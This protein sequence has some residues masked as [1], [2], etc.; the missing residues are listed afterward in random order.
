M[1]ELTL[2]LFGFVIVIILAVFFI[3]GKVGWQLIHPIRKEITASP[4]EY[5]L[6][7]LEVF[8]TSREDNLRLKGWFLPAKESRIT[9]I[10]AHG[11]GE[12]RQ[13][14]YIPIL[15]LA[16]NLVSEGYN[17]LLFDFRNSGESEGKMTSVG[18]Y[19]TRDILGAVDFLKKEKAQ[20]AG[21]IV[22]Y[23]FS[24]GA[25][26]AILAAAEDKRIGAVIADSPFADLKSYL[27]SNLEVWTKLPAFPFNLAFML[28]TPLLT[29]LDP[30]SVSP[31]RVIK[32]LTPRPVLFIHGE[33]DQSIPSDNSRL[34][35]EVS[36][37]PHAQL[38]LVPGAGHVESYS[39]EPEKYQQKINQFLKI[40]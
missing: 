31:L 35:L 14:D 39:K 12:N 19:E 13:Y 22:V 20:Q 27:E 10:V 8:F 24:M 40:S 17:V 33:A 2:F 28:I 25:A 26:T 5:G 7:F 11:Y 37:N 3:A 23:G 6:D 4:G 21:R 15:P 16:K 34:L 30:S 36:N 29:G 9:I 1:M 32:S 18:K 38:W